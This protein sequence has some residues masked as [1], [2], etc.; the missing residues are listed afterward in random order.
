MVV[1]GCIWLVGEKLGR[2]D[3][4]CIVTDEATRAAQSKTIRR[5]AVGQEKP[6]A[7]SQL[8]LG[9]PDPSFDPLLARGFSWSI[10]TVS[11]YRTEP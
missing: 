8:S 11:G 5:F 7:T 9:L 1:T 10:P 4:I 3:A 6:L 2:R